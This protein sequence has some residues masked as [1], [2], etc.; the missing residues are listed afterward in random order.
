MSSLFPHVLFVFQQYP[1]QATTSAGIVL[2]TVVVENVCESRFDLVVVVAG[3]VI[4]DIG[5]ISKA[6]Q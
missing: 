2:H 6:G 1:L 4:C 3:F 5:G